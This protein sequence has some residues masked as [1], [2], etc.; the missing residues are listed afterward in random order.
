MEIDS[1]V[2]TCSEGVSN[3]EKQ[4]GGAAQTCAPLSKRDQMNRV[5]RAGCE[6]P[7]KKCRMNGRGVEKGMMGDGDDDCRTAMGENE[8]AQ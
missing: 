6:R 8:M 3:G 2:T 1:P 4:K 7:G 5:A